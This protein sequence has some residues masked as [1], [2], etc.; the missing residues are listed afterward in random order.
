[1]VQI[2]P[3]LLAADFSK[4]GTEVKKLTR[5]GADALHLDI[6]DGH[7]VPNLTFGPDVVRAVRS[8]SDIPFDV[9]LMVAYP[10]QF[11]E[12]FCQAGADWITFHVEADTNIA[13]TISLIRKQR[14]RVGLS[15]RPGTNVSRLIPFLP[16][17][18]LVLVMSVEPGFGGQ[19]FQKQALEKIAALKELIGKKSV[20]IS[21]DGG[22]NNV[23]AP[24]CRLAG[25][26][27]LVAGTAILKQKNYAQAIERL[28]YD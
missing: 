3:S 18:D 13:E 5:A 17:I 23:T 12:A 19:T 24:A 6:M 11:V 27:I 16:M 21:V 28:R 20:R 22:I 9:H 25:A 2:A 26:D 8:H 15:L 14:R 4:L 1:M 10:D 7:F